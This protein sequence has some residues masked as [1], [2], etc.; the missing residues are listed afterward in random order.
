MKERCSVVLVGKAG[1]EERENDCTQKR[2]KQRM[3]FFHGSKGNKRES[4]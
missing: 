1:E 3:N 4:S 2:E